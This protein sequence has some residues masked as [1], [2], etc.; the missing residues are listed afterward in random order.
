MFGLLGFALGGCFAPPDFGSPDDGVPDDARVGHEPA[1]DAAPPGI[2]A[3]GAADVGIVEDAGEWSDAAQV[4]DAAVDPGG[5]AIVGSW[6]S[7]GDDL[8]V[9]L[10]EPPASLVRL[11]VRFGDDGALLAAVTNERLQRFELRGSYTVDDSTDPAT[12][13]VLQ[14]EPE[15]ARSEGI[16]AVEGDLLT[17]EVAQVEPP[18]SNVSPP[19]AEG[20]FGSTSGGRFGRDNVQRYR[21]VP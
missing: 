3:G 12:I 21:S 2:D 10:A 19:T 17:Y 5:S 13:V 18:L 14:T 20:G 4:P 1:A 8:S 6:V 7:E 15:P 9:L 11:E 16:W